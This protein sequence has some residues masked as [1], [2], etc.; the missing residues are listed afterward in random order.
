MDIN[1]AREIAASY[2][3]EHG[4]L[5]ISKVYDAD[6]M[7]IMFGRKNGSVR[8]GSGGISIDKATKEIKPFILPSD[9]NFEILDKAMLIEI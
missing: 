5:D 8:Y 7:W 2:F 3:K 1:M 6:T 4:D 9:E